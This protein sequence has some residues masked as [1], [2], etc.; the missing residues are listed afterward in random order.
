MIIE[1]AC[2]IPSIFLCG[3][4]ELIYEFSK[5]HIPKDDD[6]YTITYTFKYKAE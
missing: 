6:I 3:D 2:I 1:S 4:M 5:P